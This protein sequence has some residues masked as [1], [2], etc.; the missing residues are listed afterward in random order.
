MEAVTEVRSLVRAMD[1]EEP[2]RHTEKTERAGAAL[3]APP[4]TR[5]V[6][7]MQA[8]SRT[9]RTTNT[10]APRR[11]IEA[12]IFEREGEPLLVSYTDGG[13]KTR[14]K[15]TPAGTTL[16]QARKLRETFR[17]R[18]D[19]GVLPTN[20]KLRI[21]D[22]AEEL[23]ESKRARLRAASFAALEHSLDK[24]ILPRI[25]NFKPVHVTAKVI[26]G[27]VRELESTLS[28]A[29][30]VRYL[31]P[32][33]ELLDRAVQAGSVPTNAWTTLTADQRPKRV[34]RDE[35][36]E[37]TGEEVRALLDA[38]YALDERPVARQRYGALIATL[39]FTGARVS[40]VLGLTWG[41]VDLLGATISIRGSWARDER[42]LGETKTRAGNRTVP[43]SSE[44][45]DALVKHKGLD[46]EDG[47][48]CFPARHGNG[49]L[50][51]WNFRDRG[52]A[53]ALKSAGLTGLVTIHD[54]RHAA[55]SYLISAGISDVDVARTL[56][57]SNA[58]VTRAVYARAFD[59]A[60]SDERVRSAL[61]GVAS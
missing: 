29:S 1:R 16:A 17:V 46:V 59:R 22:L 15:Q 30:V 52:W 24:V 35:R 40:E 25:G 51:Y 14:F 6:S 50:S 44:L 56:G 48:F 26:E 32:L 21:R 27:L 53:E 31:S 7:P 36:H 23:R 45:L 43:I 38:A 42:A 20:T 58:N 34:E 60:K 2:D 3:T 41:D 61:E 47:D 37:W 39:V 12:G 54:C 49:P 18:T 28:P 4:V 19:D 33:K 13:G 57:H 9:V 8:D 11:R 55:A 5:E 10:R